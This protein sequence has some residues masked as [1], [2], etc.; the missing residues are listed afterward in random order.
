MHNTK[1]LKE[2]INNIKHGVGSK[3]VVLI[4]YIQIQTPISLK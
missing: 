4:E 2:D 1:T 3:N